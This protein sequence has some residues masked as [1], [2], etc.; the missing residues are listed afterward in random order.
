MQDLWKNIRSTLSPLPVENMNCSPHLHSAMTVSF[1]KEYDQKPFSS[2]AV[3]VNYLIECEL[4]HRKEAVTKGN[5]TIERL[6]DSIL[7]TDSN[8]INVL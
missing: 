7:K 3:L 4:Q 2:I 6:H 8:R 1:Q 5:A